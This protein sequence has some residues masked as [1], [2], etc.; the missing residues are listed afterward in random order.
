M[1][2]IASRPVPS[3]LSEIV[4]PS[5]TALVLVDLQH[6]YVSKGGS[7]DRQGG[8][9]R[10]VALFQAASPNLQSLITAART[11]GVLVIYIQQTQLPGL[12]NESP[13]WMHALYLNRKLSPD[14]DR[15][16]QGTWGW[17]I[18]DEFAPQT[19]DITV[20]K[21]RS[22]AFVGTNLDVIL[23]ANNIQS[24]VVAG[25]ATDGCVFAT[26]LHAF[27]NDYFVVIPEDCTASGDPEGAKAALRY[28]SGWVNVVASGKDVIAQ[29]KNVAA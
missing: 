4:F 13:A 10:M 7:I 3:E 8:D 5:R 21:W 27:F 28:L 20:Q 18:T 14:I 9:G 25:V 15:C 17:Q 19:G 22:T 11:A 6:D 29:W 1:K 24:L 12:H 2:S 26:A 23:R 16:R